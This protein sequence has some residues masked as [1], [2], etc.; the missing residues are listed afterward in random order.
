MKKVVV[1]WAMGI[2]LATTVFL[3]QP[4]LLAAGLGPSGVCPAEKTDLLDIA[5]ANQLKSPPWYR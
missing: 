5:T 4:V 3:V 1:R 2:W